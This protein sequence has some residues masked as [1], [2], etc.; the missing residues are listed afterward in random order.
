MKKDVDSKRA[1]SPIGILGEFEE[2]VV[3]RTRE[4]GQRQHLMTR[5]W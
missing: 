4:S 3:Q 1:K 5:P 2:V